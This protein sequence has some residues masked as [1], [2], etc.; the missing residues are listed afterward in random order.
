MKNK[1]KGKLRK[2][3]AEGTAKHGAVRGDRR[4]GERQRAAKIEKKVRNLGHRGTRHRMAMP[5]T[6]R[7]I[8]YPLGLVVD[9]G[10][11]E[12]AVGML[13]SHR[14]REAGLTRR[15]TKIRKAVS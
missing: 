5:M 2:D 4:I 15:S 3:K 7:T 6:P 1:V 10:G 11:A 8:Y 12:L 9:E 14:V 13:T